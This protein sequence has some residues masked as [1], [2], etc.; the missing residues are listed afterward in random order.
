MILRY[1]PYLSTDISKPET[2]QFL[3][4]LFSVINDRHLFQ[5]DTWSILRDLVNAKIK[6]FQGKVLL[7][8]FSFK[9]RS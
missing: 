2:N 6:F 4:R 3:H 9:N 7:C 1:L 5:G 8:L